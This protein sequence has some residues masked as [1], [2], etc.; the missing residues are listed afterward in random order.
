[1]EAYR[2]LMNGGYAQI[3]HD[4]VTHTVCKSLARNSKHN[5]L[6]YSTMMD[7]ICMASLSGMHG[8][9]VC[10]KISVDTKTVRLF[11]EYQGAT[12]LKWVGE[13]DLGQ[14]RAY[15]VGFISQLAEICLNLLY[16]GIQHTDLKPSNILVNMH[17]EIYLIDYNCMSIEYVQDKTRRWVES[18]GTWYYCAPEIVMNKCPSDTSMVWSLGLIYCTIWYKYPIARRVMRNASPKKYPEE[19]HEWCVIFDHMQHHYSGTTALVWRDVIKHL[20]ADTVDFVSQMLSWDPKK[21]P[22]LQEVFVFFRREPITSLE[23]HRLEWAASPT[24]GERRDPIIH[25][26]FELS[27]K[28]R[29]PHYF[30]HTVVLWDRCSSHFSFESSTAAGSQDLAIALACYALVAFMHN[31]CILSEKMFLDACKGIPCTSKELED[32]IFEIGNHLHWRLYQR[33][34]EYILLKL[35]FMTSMNTLKMLLISQSEPYTPKMIAKMLSDKKQNQT[36]NE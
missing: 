7:T 26:L 21:R 29:R 8:I 19:Q 35:G 17:R 20:P 5:G 3:Y 25:R 12:L 36:T 30:T 2:F 15:C 24:N 13:H 28:H 33:S 27:E 6:A 18:I 14:R 4:S 16:N 32:R 22:S 31:E 1:M 9:P 34:I 23:L 11:M 10:H